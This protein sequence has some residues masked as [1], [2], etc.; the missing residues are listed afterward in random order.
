MKERLRRLTPSSDIS[1]RMPPSPSLSMLIATLTY[2]TEVTIISV[3]TIRDRAPS[4]VSGPGCAPVT[5]STV[6]KA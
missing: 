3:H 5:S 1:A 4:V 6:L 2:F